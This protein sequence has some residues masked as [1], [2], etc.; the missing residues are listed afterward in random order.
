MGVKPER[1]ILQKTTSAL[2]DA[3]T[4]VPSTRRAQLPSPLSAYAAHPRIRGRAFPCGA[5][6]SQAAMPVLSEAGERAHGPVREFAGPWAKI[7]ESGYD[8]SL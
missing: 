2:A 1:E 5:R 7:N 8:N 3:I 6:D 4:S